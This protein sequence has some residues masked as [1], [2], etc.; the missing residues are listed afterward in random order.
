MMRC[1]ICK[2]KDVVKSGALSEE[3][4]LSWPIDI[5]QKKEGEA[6]KNISNERYELWKC[7][8]CNILWE[9]RPLH[10]ETMYGGETGEWVKVTEEYVRKHYRNVI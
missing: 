6:I 1:N 4:F 9:W 2:N 3:D 10:K 5:V 8:S 7:K